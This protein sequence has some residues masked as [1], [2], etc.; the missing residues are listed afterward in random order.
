METPIIYEDADFV[1][2]NKPAGLVVHG[3]GKTKEATLADWLIARYPAKGDYAGIEKVGE[4]VT[5]SNGDIIWKPGI[6]HRLDRETSGA[7]LVAKHQES[8]EFAKKQFQDRETAK[9]YHAFVYGLMKE[10]EGKGGRIDRPIGRSINDFRKWTAERGTRG[11]LREA[12]TEYTVIKKTTDFSYIE[13]RPLTGRTHQI[14]VHL[15]AINHP[16]LVDKLYAPNRA[17]PPSDNLGFTRLALH[18]LSLDFML[19]SGKTITV[20]APFPE[21]FKNAQKALGVAM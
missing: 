16:V 11:E 19:M 5:L 13:A 10:P 4:P 9:V 20:T 3:D 8:Y 18:A 14:R 1:V 12:S 7:L 15:K 6:V 21:D 17:T 2:V